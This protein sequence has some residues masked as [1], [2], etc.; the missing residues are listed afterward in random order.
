MRATL[1]ITNSGKLAGREIAQIYATY[2]DSADEPPRHI[3]IDVRELTFFVCTCE[4]V[5]RCFR[6]LFSVYAAHRRHAGLLAIPDPRGRVIEDADRFA[7]RVAAAR[8]EAV[9]TAAPMGLWVSASGYGFQRRDGGRVDG[10]ESAAPWL[11]YHVGWLYWFVI[12][13]T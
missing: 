8:D 6:L 5:P 3:R 11:D 1:T 2:P 10:A 4:S 7:A 13:G 9:V 12:R